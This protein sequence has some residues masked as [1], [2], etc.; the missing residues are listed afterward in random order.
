MT[1]DAIF[2]VVGSSLERKCDFLRATNC[3]SEREI[4]KKNFE[5]QVKKCH[6]INSLA[7]KLNTMRLFKLMKTY[8]NKKERNLLKN[9]NNA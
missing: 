1:S 3:S 8:R 7:I 4:H 2:N 6:P 9:N 5:G